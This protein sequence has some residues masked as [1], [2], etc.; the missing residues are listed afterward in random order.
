MQDFQDKNQQGEASITMAFCFF[1]SAGTS[2]L[3]DSTG[4]PRNY[5]P[6]LLASFLR[7]VYD[8]GEKLWSQDA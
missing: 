5:C 6:K 7:H 1:E 4:D 2:F 3:E 8:S